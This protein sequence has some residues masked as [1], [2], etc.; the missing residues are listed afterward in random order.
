MV[1]VARERPAGMVWPLLSHLSSQ[2]LSEWLQ[3]LQDEGLPLLLGKANHPDT[4][5]RA[6]A[7]TIRYRGREPSRAVSPPLPPACL[8]ICP[9]HLLATYLSWVQLQPTHGQMGKEEVE[10]QTRDRRVDCQSARL[11]P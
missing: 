2:F 1:E 7:L 9:C 10:H 5:T 11:P 3:A 4:H 8:P 6:R